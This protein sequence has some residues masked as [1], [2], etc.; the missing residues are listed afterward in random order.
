MPSVWAS[1]RCTLS[2]SVPYSPCHTEILTEP[3]T[4]RRQ[5]APESVGCG[6]LPMDLKKAATFMGHD[7]VFTG[8]IGK[9]AN[10]QTKEV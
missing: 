3:M 6:P 9:S 5:P 2:L 10:R 1:L 4:V 7:T 8:C